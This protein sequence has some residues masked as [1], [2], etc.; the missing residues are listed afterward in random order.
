MNNKGQAF[1]TFQLLISA[2]IALAILV[3]LLNILEGINFFNQRKPISEATDLIKSQ[4]NSPSELRTGQVV[5]FNRDDTLNSKS[6]S[7][8]SGALTSNQ[9]CVS[10]GDFIDDPG[11]FTFTSAKEGDILRFNGGQLRVKLSV[12]CDTGTEIQDDLTQNGVVDDWLGNEKC[13]EITALNQTA[14]VVAIR[15]A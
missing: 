2:V 3:L 8:N 5:T 14:C 13:Q 15:S 7:D 10:L 12:I 11:D 1:S 4:I 9:V 6:I